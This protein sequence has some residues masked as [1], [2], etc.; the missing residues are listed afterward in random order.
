MRMHNNCGGLRHDIDHLVGFLAL[1]R[2]LYEGSWDHVR[3]TESLAA[4][5]L[6]QNCH[7]WGPLLVGLYSHPRAFKLVFYYADISDLSHR[8]SCKSLELHETS[9]AHNFIQVQVELNLVPAIY[10]RKLPSLWQ[11][12]M[13]HMHGISAVCIH[14]VPRWWI[15]CQTRHFETTSLR[16]PRCNI[17]ERP[18]FM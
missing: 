12:W 17:I 1:F 11:S 2:R 7:Y 5:V 13:R 6:S 3:G 14:S 4:P 10:D 15:I 16:R 9:W 8:L 18:K